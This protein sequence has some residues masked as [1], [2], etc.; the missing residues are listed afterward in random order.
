LYDYLVDQGIFYHQYIPCVEFDNKGLPKTYTLSP[1][2]WG[3]F[4]CTIFDRW[5]ADKTRRVSVRYFDALLQYLVSGDYI[6]CHMNRE[7][8]QYFL[9]EHNGDVYPCD[10]FAESDL[11]LGNICKD[12]WQDLLT[13]Q[14]YKKFGNGK[15]NWHEDCGNCHYLQV[16]SG[17]CLK[18]RLDHDRHSPNPKS[19]LCN[20]YK[21]FFNHALQKLQDMASEI[22]KLNDLN[23]IATSN[24][25]PQ[26]KVGRN[27]SCP[28][29]SGRK[30]KKCCGFVN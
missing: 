17:D 10:F 26:V 7:C 21:M 22:K 1:E 23:Y 27:D 8:N 11:R 13:A 24:C 2:A 3:E 6:I 14:R 20:G 5:S 9:V 29:G 30:Y 15:S 16:C 12:S 4:L 18:H 28:C 19:W 25:I